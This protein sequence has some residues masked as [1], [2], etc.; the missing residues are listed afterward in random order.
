MT[1]AP[2][3]AVLLLGLLLSGCT[4]PGL[5]DPP[6]ESASA[7]DFQRDPTPSEVESF[8]AELNN[9]SR[10]THVEISYR[11][12]TFGNGPSTEAFLDTNSVKP[13]E[14]TK[15]LDQAFELTWDRTDIALGTL[16]YVVRN[17][18]TGATANAADLGFDGPTIGPNELL[19]RYGKHP[20]VTPIT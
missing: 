12:G 9:I 8:R 13:A 17:P 10:V 4:V 14:L 19:A 20:A 5:R 18:A 15:I 7:S 11:K 2:L 3:L 16:T 1:R 6:H